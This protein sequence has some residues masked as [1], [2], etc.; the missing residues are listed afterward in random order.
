MTR[1]TK[2][3]LSAFSI[4]ALASLAS[5][6]IFGVFTATTQ[7]AG[8]EISTGTVTL[9]D[10]DSGS[11]LYN[12]TGTKPGDTV[13]KCIKV[14]YNGSLPAS[15]KLYTPSS[16]GSLAQYIDVTITEGS[17]PGSTF[18]DCSN[19]AADATVFAGTLQ[20]MEQTN[21][22]FATGLQ[23]DPDAVT[24]SQGQASVYKIQATL[25]SSTPDTVQSSSS[26]VHS[27]VW[28]AHNN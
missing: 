10:N 16:P 13:T 23:A 2:L 14:T 7:N 8:N 22:T 19:F 24:W 28:E 17:Q 5:F 20:A 3:L 18:P 26:G 6:G 25:R 11:A 15:V 4:G 27:F 21:T 1:K 9:T 12:V